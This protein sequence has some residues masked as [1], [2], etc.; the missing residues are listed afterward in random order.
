MSLDN[1]VDSEKQ[2]VITEAKKESLSVKDIFARLKVFGLGIVIGLI[3]YGFIWWAVSLIGLHYA[4]TSILAFAFTLTLLF[5][6]EEVTGLNM[7]RIK[8]AILAAVSIFF[9]V[10]LL[11]SSDERNKSYRNEP[12][13][14]NRTYSL[15]SETFSFTGNER[16]ATNAVFLKGKEYEITVKGVSVNFVDHNEIKELVPRLEPYKFVA[17]TEG[18]PT[19]DGIAHGNGSRSVVTVEWEENNINRIETQ[20]FEVIQLE[21]ANLNY[22]SKKVYSKGQKIKIVSSGDVYETDGKSWQKYMGPGEHSETMTG[23]GN[24]SFKASSPATITIFY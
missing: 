17:A 24:M 10:I 22:F 1:Y 23:T 4:W 11:S 21:K 8:T 14:T 18:H 5:T 6:F 9:V 15:R 12:K 20:R 19:F 2:V 13:G 7:S 3:L 16:W